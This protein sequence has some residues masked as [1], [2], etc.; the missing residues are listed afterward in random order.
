MKKKMLWYVVVIAIIAVIAGTYAVFS[1]PTQGTLQGEVTCKG[2]GGSVRGLHLVI[3]GRSTI[4]YESRDYKLTRIP[5]GTYTFKAA[6]PYYQDFEQEVDISRGETTLKFQMEGKEIP[7]LSGIIIFTEKYS[8]VLNTLI[9]ARDVSP[10]LRDKAQLNRS[11]DAIR[12]KEG[13]IIEIRLTD[14]EGIGI[15]DFPYMPVSLEGALWVRIGEEDD[16]VKGKQVFEGPID[17]FWDPTSYL[18]KY[19]GI[20]PWDKIGSVDKETQANGVLEVIL[21]TSQG[22]FSD[23]STEVSLVPTEG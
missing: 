2:S 9:S 13:I 7:Y 12:G 3:D 10:D 14:S 17:V 5:P 15:T 4:M 22:D 16:Y 1:M 23:N 11:I 8:T 18:A 21:H 20:I 6:A 19:K